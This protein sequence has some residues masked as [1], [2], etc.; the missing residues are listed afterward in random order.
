MFDSEVLF[1]FKEKLNGCH[2]HGFKGYLINLFLSSF[3]LFSFIRL[4]EHLT[5]FK[6]NPWC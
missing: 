5:V 1:F 2:F 4:H 3:P 6:S